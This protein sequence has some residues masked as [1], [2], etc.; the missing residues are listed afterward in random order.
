MQH[1][2]NSHFDGDLKEGVVGCFPLHRPTVGLPLSGR[3]SAGPGTERQ[4]TNGQRWSSS[5]TSAISPRE[6][7]RVVT[8]EI[9]GP[10]SPDRRDPIPIVARR[11]DQYG[12]HGKTG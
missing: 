6:T 1:T 10:C 7:S 8:A 2:G 3:D 11:K 5:S 9:R 4:V 12:G